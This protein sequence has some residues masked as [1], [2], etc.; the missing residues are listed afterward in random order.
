MVTPVW[1]TI[2]IE[3]VYIMTAHDVDEWVA[4]Y[5]AAWRDPQTAVL[6][7]LFEKG[8]V[9]IPSPWRRPL[10]G[11]K[12]ISDFWAKAG[13]GSGERFTM[14]HELASHSQETAVIRIFVDY[15]DGE[16]W[17]DLWIVSFSKS[18]K[19]SRFEEWPFKSDQALSLI[20]I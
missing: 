19:A 9:Y 6:E 3:D 18:G 4:Q 11:L 13:G 8:A 12:E 10:R 14:R 1:H 16:Q 15:E 5:E 17:R 7:K 2:L 20:H